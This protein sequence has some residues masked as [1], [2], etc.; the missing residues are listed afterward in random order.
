MRFALCSL[1]CASSLPGIFITIQVAFSFGQKMDGARC[2][3]LAVN[4]RITAFEAFFA[5]VDIMLQTA[6]AGFPVRVI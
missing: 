5:H 3:V 6:I 1:F 4:L 2:T